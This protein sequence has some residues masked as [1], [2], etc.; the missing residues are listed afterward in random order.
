M[1]HSVWSYRLDLIYFGTQGRFTLLQCYLILKQTNSLGSLT[2]TKTEK[3]NSKRFNF[4]M[5]YVTQ[6]LIQNMVTIRWTICLKSIFVLNP[7]L[8]AG[9]QCFEHLLPPPP[10]LKL[11]SSFF[12]QWI[13]FLTNPLS[14]PSPPFWKKNRC[15]SSGIRTSNLFYQ[16]DHTCAKIQNPETRILKPERSAPNPKP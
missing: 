1:C 12:L 15:C 13:C 8:D 14:P 10:T 6:I 5:K 11:P 4:Q 3:D 2:E 9:K 7:F 16:M